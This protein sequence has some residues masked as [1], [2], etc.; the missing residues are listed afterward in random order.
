MFA[1]GTL[2]NKQNCFD[3]FQC[4][5]EFLIQEKYTTASR[6]AINGAS[7]GGLLV[8]KCRVICICVCMCMCVSVSVRCCIMYLV[9]P[10]QYGIFGA[11]ADIKEQENSDRLYE[12]ILSVNVISAERGYQTTVRNM[13]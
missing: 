2:G 3:D 9:G 5:A 7:N 4:A 10:D 8:G 11:D 12:P 1:G 6:I 13:I